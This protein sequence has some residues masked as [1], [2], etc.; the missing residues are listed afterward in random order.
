MESTGYGSQTKEVKEM[1]AEHM[2]MKALWSVS[3]SQNHGQH[4]HFNKN[5]PEGIAVAAL[6]HAAGDD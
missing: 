5:S 6:E 1:D 3:L 2:A 4:H